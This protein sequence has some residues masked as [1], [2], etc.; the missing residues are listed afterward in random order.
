VTR[1]KEGEEAELDASS[2]NSRSQKGI[3]GVIGQLTVCIR[4]VVQITFLISG[5]DPVHSLLARTNP[6]SKQVHDMEGFDG[7]PGPPINCA[8]AYILACGLKKKPET[9][10]Q[11]PALKSGEIAEAGLFAAKPEICDLALPKLLTLF[12]QQLECLIG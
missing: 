3:R 7:T 12:L 9:P 5:E 4:C 8:E 11:H 6:T 10:A 2:I 1:R